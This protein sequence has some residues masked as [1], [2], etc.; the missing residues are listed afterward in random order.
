MFSCYTKF[1]NGHLM[2]AMITT[3]RV[4]CTI[5]LWNVVYCCTFLWNCVIAIFSLTA[6]GLY[7]VCT[8]IN[9][10]QCKGTST[11][12]IGLIQKCTHASKFIASTST[13]MVYMYVNYCF[14]QYC[15]KQ[16]Y[17]NM[18]TCIGMTMQYT[19]LKEICI[20]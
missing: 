11:L 18:Y 16:W 4:T 12:N 14:A 13:Y 9:S 10:K 6:Q 15:L 19:H 7:N 17:N 8:Y 1:N 2:L 5:F 3:I 20:A